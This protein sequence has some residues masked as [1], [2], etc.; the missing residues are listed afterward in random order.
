MAVRMILEPP[1]RSDGNEAK[2]YT[3]LDCG[4]EE[5]YIP[6][7]HSKYVHQSKHYIVEDDKYNGYYV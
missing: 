2:H 7:L 4:D 3:C 1:K 6:Y 5:L